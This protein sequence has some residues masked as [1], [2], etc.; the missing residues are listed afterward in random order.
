M[1]WCMHDIL[2]LLAQYGGWLVFFNVL[3]EQAGLPVS[4]Y[5]LL[6]AVATCLMRG[7]VG[8]ICL[9]EGG[10]DFMRDLLRESQQVAAASDHPVTPL[11]RLARSHLQVYQAQRAIGA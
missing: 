11:L 8:Q 7:S 4:A 2:S 1:A 6:V 9:T 5:P 3:T 10:V